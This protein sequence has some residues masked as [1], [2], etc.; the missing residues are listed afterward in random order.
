MCYSKTIKKNI[1]LVTLLI[2]AL[3]LLPTMFS[4]CNKEPKVNLPQL[5]KTVD[6]MV[7]DSEGWVVGPTVEVTKITC[8][9]EDDVLFITITGK[10]NQ[11]NYMDPCLIG[12]RLLDSQGLVVEESTYI[13]PN[14]NFSG[15]TLEFK[16]IDADETYTFEL[17]NVGSGQFGWSVIS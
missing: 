2:T 12:Y 11:G 10:G 3:L 7:Y 13:V 6:I 17:A 5:P 14:G 15:E 16:N 4:S 9:S 1:L 8:K